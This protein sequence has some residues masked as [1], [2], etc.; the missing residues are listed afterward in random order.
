MIGLMDAQSRF[1]AK[2]GVQF[3]TFATLRIKGAML[4]ELRGTDW[5]PRSVRKNQRSIGQAIHTVEQRTK[6]SAT[7]SEIAAEMGVMIYTIVKP[8]H[9]H[10]HFALIFYAIFPFKQLNYVFP[11]QHLSPID[12]VQLHKHYLF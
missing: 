5:I 11:V 6:R 7:E 2:Q 9:A 4:D 1:D 12:G 3:E 8:T 10:C